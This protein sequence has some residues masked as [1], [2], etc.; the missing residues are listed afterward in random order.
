M[1]IE[2]E[3]EMRIRPVTIMI[4]H[5]RKKWDKFHTLL[6]AHIHKISKNHHFFGKVVV[7][8]GA[9][10]LTRTGDLLITS[11]GT[12]VLYRILSYR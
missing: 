7:F 5:R 10:D 12:A 9:S 3:H 8:T 1:R 6:S 2:V 11:G 4:Y